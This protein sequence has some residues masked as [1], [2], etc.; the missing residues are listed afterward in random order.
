MRRSQALPNPHRASQWLFIKPLDDI[1]RNTSTFYTVCDHRPKLLNT[2][3]GFSLKVELLLL[4]VAA[5][6][7]RRFHQLE[8]TYDCT[9]FFVKKKK[10]LA[11]CTALPLDLNLNMKDGSAKRTRGKQF[12]GALTFVRPRHECITGQFSASSLMDRFS[13]R[14]NQPCA[15]LSLGCTPA[16]RLF[17]HHIISVIIHHS[18][19]I[20][21]QPSLCWAICMTNWMPSMLISRYFTPRLD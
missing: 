21:S 18:K 5:C 11:Y 8:L 13:V 17:L 19:L 14:S 20:C 4:H 1:L 6:C 2:G 12:T 3:G 16:Q 15:L 7:P 9:A 10:W